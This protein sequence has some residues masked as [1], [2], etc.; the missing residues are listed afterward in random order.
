[1]EIAQRNVNLKITTMF[2]RS[3]LM[4]LIDIKVL[5]RWLDEAIGMFANCLYS[6]FTWE[7][8]FIMKFQSSG[9]FCDHIRDS[10]MVRTSL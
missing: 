7:R 1:M 10:Y 4:M 3:F 8:K 6:N 2:L 5:L 9:L